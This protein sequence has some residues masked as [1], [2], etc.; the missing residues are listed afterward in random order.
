MEEMSKHQV[1]QKYA[2]MSVKEIREAMLET[3]CNEDPEMKDTGNTQ[4]DLE[5]INMLQSECGSSVCQ[6]MHLTEKQKFTSMV[7][8]RAPPGSTIQNLRP[9]NDNYAE[10]GFDNILSK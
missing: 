9:Q 8:V 6:D 2:Y 10:Q 4:L 5:D 7:I 1:Y 3:P